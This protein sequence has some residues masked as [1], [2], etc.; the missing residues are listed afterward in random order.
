MVAAFTHDGHLIFHC[1]V[2]QSG[3][4][5]AA[6]LENKDTA[7]LMGIDVNRIIVVTFAVGACRWL[8]PAGSALFSYLP[9]GNIRW[10]LLRQY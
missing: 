4:G 6:V 8:V 10:D 9:P 7:A 3:Q 5:H 2:Y 1:S